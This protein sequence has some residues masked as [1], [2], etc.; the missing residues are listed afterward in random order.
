MSAAKCDWG[1]CGRP[2]KFQI[3]LK[4]WALLT[5]GA[6]RNDRNALKMLTSVCVC[7]ECAPKVKPS[8]FLLQE[9]RVRIAAALAKIGKAFPD[10]DAAEIALEEII[11]KPID[12]EAEIRTANIIGKPVW[13]G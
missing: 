8:D 4:L 11:D 7:E 3:G 6:A 5:P 12:L 13:E 1:G 10:F 2:G 9:G